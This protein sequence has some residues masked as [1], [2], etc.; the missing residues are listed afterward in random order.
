MRIQI[1]RGLQRRINATTDCIRHL[2]PRPSSASLATPV[3][4]SMSSHPHL[5]RNFWMHCLEGGFY[6]SGLAYLAP[7]TVLPVFVKELNGPDWLIALLPVILPAMF[8]LPALAAGPYVEQLHRHHPF[9]CVVG[10]LQRL[11]YLLAGLLLLFAPQAAAAI[12]PIIILTPIVSGLVGG[13]ASQ[14][15]MEMVT[16]MVPP[17]LR[18]SGWAIR[19]VIQGVIGLS[20]GPVI[21]WMFTHHPGVVGYAWLH[22]ICFAFLALSAFCQWTMKEAQGTNLLRL[23]RPPFRLYLRELPGLLARQPLLIR[24][25]LVRFTGTGYLMLV[26]FMSIHALT[27]T[28][29]P[30]ADAGHLLLAQMIGALIGN[31]FAGWW[32]NRHGGRVVLLFARVLSLGICLALP[33]VQSFTA[34]FIIFFVWGF[35]LYAERVGDLTFAA[36][37][38]PH[39]RR[40][41]YQAILS[42]CQALCLLAAVQCGALLYHA[43]NSFLA[44]VALCGAFAVVSILVLLTI[45]EARANPQQGHASPAMG[46]DAPM[47]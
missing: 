29:R 33:W 19:Y 9:V 46:E 44:L 42:F 40:P 4:S 37:L 11:P 35:G 36:E 34:F 12:L 15:W 45:P 13:F 14:A 28:D 27:V 26:A 20:A 47:V 21:H 23:P 18:A 7:E 41:T 32:G 38:C 31:V 3:R 5:R 43:M 16:R 39:H 2:H 25:I 24:F 10:V 8:A 30:T 22:L 17:H 1:A 6:M